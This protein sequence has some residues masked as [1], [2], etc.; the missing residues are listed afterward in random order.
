MQPSHHANM[1][2][3]FGRAQSNVFFNEQK[4]NPLSKIHE[5]LQ[6]TW[7]KNV[8]VECQLYVN[9]WPTILNK[10]R[11]FHILTQMPLTT[12]ETELDYYHQKVNNQVAEIPKKQ[13]LKVLKSVV[14]DSI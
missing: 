1:L 4:G 14:K 9:H 11:L 7:S 5:T 8:Y 10:C 2:P 12:I 13:T 6:L 3:R